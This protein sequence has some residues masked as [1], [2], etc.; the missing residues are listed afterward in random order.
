MSDA[1]KG[2]VEGAVTEAKKYLESESIDELKAAIEKLQ[3]VT[4]KVAGEMY[5]QEGGP[6]GPGPQGPGAQGGPG[7]QGPGAQSSEGQD[8]GK[9]DKKDDDVV[10]ADFKEV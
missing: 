3:G 2:E 1:A 9:S 4:H 5:Q 8:S 6:Q 10:D 7:P